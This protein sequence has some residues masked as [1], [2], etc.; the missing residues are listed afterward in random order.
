[1]LF[2]GYTENARRAIFFAR[3][4]ASAARSD[5]LRPAHLLLGLL[6]EAKGLFPSA[7]RSLDEIRKSVERDFGAV[8]APPSKDMDIPFDEP[9]MLALTF[10]AEEAKGLNHRNVDTPHLLFGLNRLDAKM[11]ER[12]TGLDERKLSDIR[13]KVK[14]THSVPG[15]SESGRAGSGGDSKP[16]GTTLSPE[17]QAVLQAITLA[18]Q[19]ESVS[20]QIITRSGVQTFSFQPNPPEEHS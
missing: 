14:V 13:E 1:M 6:R 3:Y 15:G 2:E 16:L 11:I 19:Q 12:H 5:Y 17:R 8:E 10:A 20:I 4:E 18:L 7:P 9:A